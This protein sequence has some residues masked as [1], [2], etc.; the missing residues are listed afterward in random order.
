MLWLFSNQGFISLS[1]V[2]S[3]VKTAFGGRVSW[4]AGQVIVQ[5][6]QEGQVSPGTNSGSQCGSE[7]LEKSQFLPLFPC[8]SCAA[9]TDSSRPLISIPHS[10][11]QYNAVPT[12]RP[13]LRNS[14]KPVYLGKFQ[15]QERDRM[16]TDLPMDL[17]ATLSPTSAR[18]KGDRSWLWF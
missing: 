15:D 7:C 1:K 13:F 18:V 9:R 14:T 4:K 12:P 5:T 2:E 3:K 6:L 11:G 17:M 8:V 16:E 10:C